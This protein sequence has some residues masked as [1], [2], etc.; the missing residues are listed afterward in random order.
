M[1][2]GISSQDSVVRGFRRTGQGPAHLRLTT[3]DPWLLTPDSCARREAPRARAGNGTRTR[4]P[5][6]GK[7]VLYQLSYSRNDTA[8]QRPARI[9]RRVEARGIEPLTS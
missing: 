2:P 5:N 7:V 8:D 6:L 9:G 4:D 3:P 1:K